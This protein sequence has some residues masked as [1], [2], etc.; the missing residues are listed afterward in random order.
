MSP[1]KIIATHNGTFHCDEVF[2]CAMLLYTK[3]YSGAGI[4]RTRDPT[5]IASADIAVDVGGVYEPY[6]HRFDHHQ[7]SFNETFG[8]RYKTRLSSAGLIYKHFGREVLARILGLNV[9]DVTDD[10]YHKVYTSFVQAID[11]NDNGVTAYDGMKNYEVSTDLPSRVSRMNPVWN[12][13]VGID[14]N[15]RFHDAINLVR[16]EF[17]EAIKDVVYVWLP[18]RKIVKDAFSARYTVHTSGRIMY[19]GTPCPWQSHLY[20]IEH[21]EHLAGQVL[22]VIFSD[23]SGGFR[24]RAVSEETSK[25]TNRHSLPERWRGYDGSALQ[26]ECGVADAIFVHTNGFIGGAS[27]YDGALLMATRA[28]PSS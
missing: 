10:V 13:S 14:A 26:E 20:D 19:I 24:V 21:D 4:V 16:T 25:F 22:F 15:V 2:A 23:S 28:L 27:S 8:P 9:S 17:V 1:V 5:T 7:S 18:A 11:G 6:T 12:D 3:E